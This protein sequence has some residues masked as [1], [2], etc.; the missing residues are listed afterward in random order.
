V[1]LKTG[2]VDVEMET[3]SKRGIKKQQGSRVGLLHIPGKS[4]TSS[5]NSMGIGL[6][7]KIKWEG[8]EDYRAG[9]LSTCWGG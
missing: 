2:E 3:G 8:G 6:G 5:R 4:Q 9:K 1:C 7:T